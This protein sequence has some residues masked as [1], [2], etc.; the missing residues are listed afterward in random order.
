MFCFTFKERSMPLRAQ[1]TKTYG[2]S[3]KDLP[4]SQGHDH[5]FLCLSVPRDILNVSA[6]TCHNLKTGTKCGN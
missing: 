5:I 2:V 6:M 3:V 1:N 4:M